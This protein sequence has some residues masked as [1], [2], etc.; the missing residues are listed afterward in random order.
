MSTAQ[1]TKQPASSPVARFGSA[2]LSAIVRDLES[3]RVIL[4]MVLL[5]L[6]AEDNGSI[7]HGDGIGVFR[8]SA[9]IGAVL[10]RLCSVRDSLMET[11]DAP[12]IDWPTPFALASALDSALWDGS[13]TTASTLTPIETQTA[14]HVIIDSLDELLG[15]CVAVSTAL[16]GPNAPGVL[17]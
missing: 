14:L 10:S 12:P 16:G 8:W 7:S 9:A 15:D 1:T 17:Q 13:C 4:R 3:A 11:S 5:A 6:Y 2:H